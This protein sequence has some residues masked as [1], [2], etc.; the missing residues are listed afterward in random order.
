[1]LNVYQSTNILNRHIALVAANLCASLKSL[2]AQKWKAQFMPMMNSGSQVRKSLGKKRGL[3]I[4]EIL[5]WD[6]EMMV[7]AGGIPIT[8]TVMVVI[9]FYTTEH[10][11]DDEFSSFSESSL[12]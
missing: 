6:T 8:S 10:T 9:S 5:K 7:W 4:R 1:M 12:C 2:L 11:E 3:F